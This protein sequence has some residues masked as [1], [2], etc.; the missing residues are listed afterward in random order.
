MHRY[1][2]HWLLWK[3][4]S[5]RGECFTWMCFLRNGVF[6]AM[7]FT[8]NIGVEMVLQKGLSMRNVSVSLCPSCKFNIVSWESIADEMCFSWKCFLRNGVFGAMCFTWNI[9]FKM[10]LQKRLSMR[11]VSVSLCPSC[12]FNIVS[13]ESIADKMCFAWK[14]FLRNGVFGAMCF[15]SACAEIR[16]APDEF[17]P[18]LDNRCFLFQRNL[19]CMHR[20]QGQWLWMFH[21]KHWCKNNVWRTYLYAD[22]RHR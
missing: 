17:L 10:V 7:C 2:G 19:C 22:S 4:L 16:K 20:C 5:P 6:G 11:D 13:W 21:V 3:C 9:G 15:L 12:K 18:H 14:C 8:W 1:Q